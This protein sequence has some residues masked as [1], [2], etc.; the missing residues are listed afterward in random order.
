MMFIKA[1]IF[2]SHLQ[3]ADWLEARELK[4]EELNISVLPT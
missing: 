1:D 3:E 2:S 4:N